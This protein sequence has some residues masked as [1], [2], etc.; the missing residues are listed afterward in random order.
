MER[1]GITFEFTN[2]MQVAIDA[3]AELGI[4]T[5][6]LDQVMIYFEKL[7]ANRRENSALSPPLA[8]LKQ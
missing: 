5:K 2:I 8:T 1:R 4:Q 7:N 3:C 6:T